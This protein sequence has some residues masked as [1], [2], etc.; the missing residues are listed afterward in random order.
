MRESC[1]YPDHGICVISMNDIIE[2]YAEPAI[3]RFCVDHNVQITAKSRDVS[4]IIKHFIISTVI[5]QLEIHKDHK[6]VLNY[7][8]ITQSALG[9]DMVDKVNHSISQ[10]L[11]QFKFC[12]TN[13]DLPVHLFDVEHL[14]E[15]RSVIENCIVKSR[16]MQS[17]KQFLAK[18]QLT[19]LNARVD[20]IA[21]NYILNK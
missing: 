7:T 10:I 20:H 2:H 15:I 11:K 8:P 17:I 9:N 12:S 13:I 6:V 14:Y 4:K 3:L 1:V 16:K 21:T 19:A 18:H 5:N